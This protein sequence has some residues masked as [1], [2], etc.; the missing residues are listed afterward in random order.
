V[1]LSM[2]QAQSAAATQS[3]EDL[4][5]SSYESEAEEAQPQPAARPISKLHRQTDRQADA[6]TPE[7]ASASSAFGRAL[8]VWKLTTS[9]LFDLEAKI[10]MQVRRRGGARNRPSGDLPDFLSVCL[11]MVPTR[12]RS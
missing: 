10:V 5:T 4:S 3:F 11:P 1:R 12:H 7:P 8:S 2:Q 6:R 9:R